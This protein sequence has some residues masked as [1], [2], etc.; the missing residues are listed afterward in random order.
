MFYFFDEIFIGQVKALLKKGSYQDCENAIIIN[1]FDVPDSWLKDRSASLRL[2]PD[3]ENPIFKLRIS[4]KKG[5]RTSYRIYLFLLS[6]KN[7]LYFFYIYPKTGKLGKSNLQK[8]ERKKA[9][10]R[11]NNNIKNNSFMEVYLNTTNR[12]ICYRSND[13][14]VW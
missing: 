2:N 14:A 9:I 11:L 5:K 4:H 13:R 7:N 1:I 6:K 10:K 3:P 12:K 8:E